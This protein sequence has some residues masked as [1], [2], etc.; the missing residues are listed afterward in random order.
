M[1][2]DKVSEPI[3]PHTPSDGQGPDNGSSVVQETVVEDKE[4]LGSNT[5]LTK[6]ALQ[7][8]AKRPAMP[9]CTPVRTEMLCSPVHRSIHAAAHV[10]TC[11]LRSPTRS[12]QSSVATNLT[13]STFYTPRQS[14]HA[15]TQP[16][17]SC[18]RVAEHGLSNLN[19]T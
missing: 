16:F 12:T 6:Q 3:A 13:T 11:V 10:R 8:V 19:S 7:A 14:L 5:T 4:G 17:S 15:D 9:G 2:R 1:R 18:S